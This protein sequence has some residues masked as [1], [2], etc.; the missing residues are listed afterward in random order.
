MSAPTGA[1]TTW[2]CPNFL[3]DLIVTASPTRTP[4]LAMSGG[5]NGVKETNN[6][7]FA[8]DQEYTQTAASQ[9]S[10]T[11]DTAIAGAPTAITCVRSQV[12]NT[13]QIVQEQVALSYPKISNMGKLSSSGVLTSGTPSVPTN[14]LDWQIAKAMEKISRDMEYSIIQGAYVAHTVA[15]TAST[16]RG[17]SAAIVEGGTVVAAGNAALTL[18]MIKTLLRNM[19]VAGAQFINPVFVVNAFQKQ[20]LSTLF[21]YA[22]T[23]RNIGGVNIKQIETDFGNIG[24]LLDAFQVTSVVGLYDLSFVSVVTC[25]VPGKGNLFLEPLAKIGASEKHQIYGQLGLDH[26]PE[27]M[28]GHISGLATS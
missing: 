6:F 23:D 15:S 18:T 5:L 4:L 27:F 22:P 7:M 28:H 3:G 9:P 13:C 2:N 21:G 8:I 25:P 20:M 10:I 17:L 16:T 14:E 1:G 19:Y 12:A 26:G 24:V 11:E